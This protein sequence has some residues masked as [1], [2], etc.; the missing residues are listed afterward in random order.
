MKGKYV[1]GNLVTLSSYSPVPFLSV[2]NRESTITNE[3]PGILSIYI[4]II[5]IGPGSYYLDATNLSSL[6]RSDPR[7]AAFRNKAPRFAPNCPG[8]NIYNY[9]SSYLNPGPGVYHDENKEF[10]KTSTIEKPPKEKAGTR[11]NFGNKSFTLRKPERPQ[12]ETGFRLTIPSIP[13]IY[14][15]YIIYIGKKV[16][17]KGYK[18]VGKDT[19]GPNHY[20]PSFS[21]ISGRVRG[22]AFSGL[23]EKRK[24]ST[25][26]MEE[27]PGPGT[28]DFDMKAKVNHNIF[29]NAAFINA[30]L[31]TSNIQTKEANPPTKKETPG[32]L[33]ILLI[34]LGPGAY[35]P[36][37][38]EKL[39]QAN[40]SNFQGGFGTITER[41][42]VYAYLIIL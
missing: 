11:T 29:G 9:P 40:T 19:V 6:S 36:G 22:T 31:N 27:K 38:S 33:Y 4:Y 17:R 18:G 16:A 5:Y 35:I 32:N 1:L 34:L 30:N 10:V 41:K 14:I 3:I 28:Y 23:K 20:T 2:Q 13:S 21:I 37:G 8:A 24:T 26:L 25:S 42:V 12:T 15:I 7:S 39:V